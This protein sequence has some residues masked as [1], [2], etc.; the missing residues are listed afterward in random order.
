MKVFKKLKNWITKSAFISMEYK[1][2]STCIEFFDCDSDEVRS[3]A[4]IKEESD[5]DVCFEV[6]RDN[7]NI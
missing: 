4:F 6:P 2:E 7:K 3:Y 5:N 1:Y